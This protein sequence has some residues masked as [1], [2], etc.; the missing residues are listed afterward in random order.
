MS[1]NVIK[2]AGPLQGRRDVQQFLSDC[3][4]PQIKEELKQDNLSKQLRNKMHT[5]SIVKHMRIEFFNQKIQMYHQLIDQFRS[6]NLTQIIQL[7][8]KSQA[9]LS[10]LQRTQR[11]LLLKQVFTKSLVKKNEFNSPLSDD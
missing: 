10:P 9:S 11:M 6:M 2:P 3:L 5:S 4:T 7:S 1:S 8:R